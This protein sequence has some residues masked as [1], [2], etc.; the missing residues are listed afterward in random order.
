VRCLCLPFR[1]SGFVLLNVLFS[2]AAAS[3]QLAVNPSSVNFS[4]VQIGSSATHS[5]VLGNSGQSNVTVSQATVVGSGFSLSG[6]ALPLTLAAGQKAVFSVSFTPKSS[7]SLSGILSLLS[8]IPIIHDR[9]GKHNSTSSTST[10]VSLTGTCTALS[11]ASTTPGQLVANPGS[12]GFA[13]VQ[14][15]SSQTQSATVTN[16]GGS[17]V[18]IAQATITGAGF[19][20]SGLTLPLTLTVGQSVTFRVT[21]APLSAGSASGRISVSSDASTPAL[22]VSLAGTGATQGQLAVTPASADFGTV[23]VGT[24]QSQRAT[25]TASASSVTVSSASVTS[26]EFSLSGIALPLTLAA[27]QSIPFTLMFTPQMSGM[28]SATVSF[29]SNTA[30]SAA[31]TLTGTGAVPP[32]HSV[33][34]SWNGASG[35]VGYNVYRGSQSGGPYAKINSVLDAS[36]TYTDSSVQGGQAYYYVTTAVD[37]GGA[38]SGYSN[39]IKAV[40]PSP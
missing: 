27:G 19:S 4:N 26:P 6:P 15:G 33:N 37:S 17:S 12:L 3:G 39:E 23:T 36:T 1:A 8:L 11:T 34:L 29:T 30:N 28:A 9:S 35:V 5:L 14:V 32:P 22:T 16:S 25:L 10:T 21:F 20:L 7:G 31:E 40:I 24:T 18:T 13:T 2:A 38:Q